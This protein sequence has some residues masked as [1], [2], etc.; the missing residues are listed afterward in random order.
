MP[1]Q[2][3][4]AATVISAAMILGAWRQGP[5]DTATRPLPSPRATAPD[6]CSLLT[7]GEVSAALEVSAQPG[8][9]LIEAS[10]A[11]CIWSTDPDNT[12]RGRRVTLSIIPVAGFEFGKS[13]A[14]PKITIVPVNGIGDEAYYE[15]F[16]SDSPFL[17]VRKGGTAF[18]LRILNGLKLKSF[19]LDQEKAKEADL[20][21]SAAARL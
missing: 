18:T 17:V 20:G 14:N 21:R 6:A 12:L 5:A 11:A 3:I 7:V 4:L 16:K 10:P 9:R 2:R 1:P 13:G 15:V 8:K 19:S